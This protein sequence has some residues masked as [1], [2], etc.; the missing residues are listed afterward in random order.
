VFDT[1]VES[2]PQKRGLKGFLSSSFM[3][4]AIHFAVIYGAVAATLKGAEI[5]QELGTDTNMVFLTE[6]EPEPEQEEPPPP[7]IAALNP[8]P[9]G[10]QTLIAPVEIPTEIPPVNLNERFDPRDYTGVGVEGGIAE[11]VEG[12]TGPVDLDAVF[13]EAVVDEPPIRLSGPP[14]LYPPL[15]K[16]AQIEG[17]VIVEVVIGVDGHPE[18]DSF[19]IIES[20]NRAFERSARNAV[21]G[22]VYRPGRMR[23][24]PVRVL[25]RQPIQFNIQR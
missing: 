1:L 11:G 9:K 17:Y 24:Q 25:V 16:D 4:F 2:K 21:L 7:E 22:S 12:G 19:R 5:V 10:F 15:L 23:G 8:P 6:Q 14:V 20:S 3:S 13:V 18:P